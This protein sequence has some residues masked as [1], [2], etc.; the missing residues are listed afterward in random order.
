M[1]EPVREKLGK[2]VAFSLTI[3]EQETM[4]VVTEKKK[5]LLLLSNT[6]LFLAKACIWFQRLW[7]VYLLIAK[8]RNYEFVLPVVQEETD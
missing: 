8:C 3:L 7:R 1:K 6:D 4:I 2:R 5:I